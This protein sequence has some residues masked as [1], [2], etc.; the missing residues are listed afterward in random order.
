MV[1]VPGV[2]VSRFNVGVDPKSFELL[3]TRI[4][5]GS[6]TFIVLVIYRPGS[7][8]VTSAFFD[9]LSGTFER[10]VGYNE[11]IYIVGDLNVRLD[12][13]NDSNAR[14]LTDLFHAFGFVVCNARST[15]VLGGLLDVV[16]TRRDLPSPC[17]ATYEA[18]LS[19]HQLLQWS[20]PVSRPD[21]P[22]VSVNR[23]PWHLLHVDKLLEALCESRLCRPDSWADCFVDD[24]ASL[25]N[26]ELDHTL[27]SLIPVKTVTC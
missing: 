14:Q 15:H 12:R 22:V 17:V 7:V 16:A 3:C 18:G 11:P 19:D 23:R 6:S 8:P 26:N 21:Q 4:T 13:D 20:V 1:A 27:D 2:N 25:Y 24:L 10:V 9:D 5:S